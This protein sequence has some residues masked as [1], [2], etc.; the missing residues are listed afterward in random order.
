MDEE[1][2][3]SNPSFENPACQVGLL[4]IDDQEFDAIRRLV[5]RQFGINLTDQKRSLVVGRLQKLMRSRGFSRFEQYLKYVE[6]DCTNRAL[7]ELINRIATNHTYFFRER[8][9]FDFFR[10]NVLPEIVAR[11]KT[12][13]SK[14]IRIWCAGCS[15]GEE[16][17]GLMMLIMDFFGSE[18][19]LWDAGLLATDI[20]A[21]A[22]G[23]AKNG[24]Y[25]ED[26]VNGVPTDYKRRYFHR[27]PC[28]D[29][30][31]N[32]MVKKEIVFRRF[33]LMNAQFPFKKA[34]DV[35][36]CRNVMIYFDQPTRETLVTKF[37]N[38]T[39]PGGYL[40]IGH[41]ESL[42]GATCP[43]DYVMPAVYRR[44]GEG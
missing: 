7:D 29:W 13:H 24:L 8:D 43:Y 15:T 17:Y 35:I 3:P 42:R 44:R 22:L 5:Y 14:D 12:Q 23:T 21:P 1:M 39:S 37:F 34:F 26:R 38:L 2:S 18:Y 10:E 16:S 33:N 31:V 32:D 20:S 27:T 41:S 36:F 6:S 40:F 4:S 28:G 25:T 11:K 9:H 30:A 19:G